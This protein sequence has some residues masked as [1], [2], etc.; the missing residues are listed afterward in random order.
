[1]LER[2]RILVTGVSTTDSIAFAVA[3]EAQLAGAELVL[4]SF[5]RFARLARR[6]AARLPRPCDVLELD[7]TKPADFARVR[8]ELRDRF[9]ELD[10]VVHAIAHAPPDA[11]SGDFLS[12]PS[13]SAATAFQTSAYSFK[14][15]AAAL[16]PLMARSDGSTTST[17]A[18]SFESTVA[19]P[20]YDWMGV[21]KAALESIARYLAR[22]L[23][24]SGIRA[25]VVS[26]GPVLTVAA[27]QIPEFFTINDAYVRRA[28]IGW[29]HTDPT[30]IAK[31]VCFL[32]SDWSRGITGETLHVDGG[33]RIVGCPAS[34]G[35]ASARATTLEPDT[36]E[37]WSGHV[38]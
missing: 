31:A 15:L 25:N 11:L 17:V 5:G 37:A 12:T 10:G 23:G 13:E 20:S 38:A 9:G 3:R 36:S 4:T 18:L 1:M 29:D 27:S 14:S 34:N 24:P 30:P 32:L 28:P 16:A 26:A 35:T 2:R 19:W 8:D 7:V 22:D 33:C 6:A 21:C